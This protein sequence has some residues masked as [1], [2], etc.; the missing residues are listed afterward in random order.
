M[1]KLIAAASIALAAGLTT[2]VASPADAAPR[3]VRLEPPVRH[4]KH[5]KVTYVHK[6]KSYPKWV[7]FNTGSLWSLP[8]CKH[9]DSRNCFYDAKRR[10]NGKGRSFADIKGKT[11]YVKGR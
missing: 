11:Y 3:A 5:V 8:R 10:G 6:S 9:E 2:F 7:E 1:K 4:V